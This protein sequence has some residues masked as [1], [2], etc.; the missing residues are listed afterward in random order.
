MC[1]GIH[2]FY[3]LLLKKD[4]QNSWIHIHCGFVLLSNLEEAWMNKAFRTL[5][6]DRRPKKLFP[7][8]GSFIS[9]VLGD[10]DC[11][12]RALEMPLELGSC[13]NLHQICIW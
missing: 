11:I 3:S 10:K 8:V 6:R 12:A 5:N 9:Y 13:D 4:L 2:V 1:P 7:S